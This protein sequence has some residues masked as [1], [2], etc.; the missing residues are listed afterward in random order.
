MTIPY[1]AYRKMVLMAV[2][3]M[4]AVP[5]PRMNATR[6]NSQLITTMP[7]SEFAGV[8]Y[9]CE[10]FFN[11]P[12]AGSPAARG[13]AEGRR[14]GGGGEGVVEDE[15]E[16]HATGGGDRRQAAEG[17][18]DGD[19]G[20]QDVA[21][22]AQVV[23]QDVD[24]G[25]VTAEVVLARLAEVVGEWVREERGQVGQVGRQ[26]VEEDEAHHGRDGH[27]EEDAP[28]ARHAGADGLFYNLLPTVLSI[29]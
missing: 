3:T 4:M 2:T 1:A 19:A 18:G 29:V 11:Q 22:A 27:R 13:E 10:T 9:L 24:H 12:E 25:E 6:V 14:P 7:I 8:R 20:R 28:G 21:Q 17:H 15:G 23:G 5:P 26:R 16:E